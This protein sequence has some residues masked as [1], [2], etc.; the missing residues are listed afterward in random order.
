MKI[1]YIQDIS[2]CYPNIVKASTEKIERLKP[3]TTPPKKEKKKEIW[4]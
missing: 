2:Q 3:L 1:H 4:L